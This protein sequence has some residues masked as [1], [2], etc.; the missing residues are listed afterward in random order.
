M[1]DEW[2]KCFEAEPSITEESQQLF[3]N[4]Q[5]NAIDCEDPQPMISS[6]TERSI[7]EMANSPRE[8]PK[9]E[10]SKCGRDLPGTYSINAMYFS[11]GDHCDIQDQ[12]ELP[13][14]CFVCG[15]RICP[16]C[17]RQH[18]NTYGIFLVCSKECDEQL[19]QIQGLPSLW[20]LK[21]AD[22]NLTD[23]CENEYRPPFY[24]DYQ[25]P[26]CGRLHDDWDC[27]CR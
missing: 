11:A 14:S 10:C 9:S 23:L 15:N 20:P 8:Q 2:M 5:G 19:R 24:W 7:R 18:G 27:D 21:V 17:A 3:E 12:L 26:R 4:A 6:E 1:Q 22:D 13:Y 16:D 25:C